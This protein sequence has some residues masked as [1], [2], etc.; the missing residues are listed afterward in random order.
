MKTLC[1]YHGNCA[2]GFGA[3]WVVRH[4][5]GDKNVEFYPAAYGKPAPDVAGRSVIIVDFSY[6]LETLQQMVEIGT[7]ILVID[8]HKTA[9]EALAQL[10]KAPSSFLL[11]MESHDQLAAHF[12][13]K[14]SGAG[15]TW[16]F[17]FPA[18]PRPALINHIEDRDLWQFKMEGTREVMAAV[19]SY[20][21]DFATWDRLMF[22]D[23]DRLW[24]DG[25]AIDRKQ[26]KDI[27]DLVGSNSRLMVIGGVS[28]PA[29]N[30]PHT[31]ASDAG[32]MLS[33]GQPFAA[34]YWDT[35][36]ARQF[37]LRST[38]EGLDVGEIAKQYGGGGHRNAAG[39]KVPGDH[40]LV[41]GHIPAQLESTMESPDLRAAL[42]EV[43]EC[44]RLALTQGEVSASRAGRALQAAGEL[45]GENLDGGEV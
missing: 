2:D 26:Q 9:A 10:P 28:V 5:L 30:L 34:I 19:F 6:P 35:A 7:S 32:H 11:W 38:D 43:T 4:A 31:M 23:I 44:L 27:A 16:D 18:T 45:L 13:M 29:I 14:R 25:L 39:F 40:E 20:P 15:M 3:A 33:Q 21:Q 12:D 1:I 37:S 8:H 24:L 36:E 41:T 17:F 22:D 42:A